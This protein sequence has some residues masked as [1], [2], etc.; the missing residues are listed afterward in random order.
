[1]DWTIVMNLPIAPTQWELSIARVK[2][3]LWATEQRA[4]VLKKTYQASFHWSS[5]PKESGSVYENCFI[6]EIW[7]LDPRQ[8]YLTEVYIK[9]KFVAVACQQARNEISKK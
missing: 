5:L 2:M 1:M 6:L 8:C 3:V 9:E 7:H 4:Q